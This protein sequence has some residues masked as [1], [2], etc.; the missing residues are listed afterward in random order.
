[1]IVCDILAISTVIFVT[2]CVVRL[3]PNLNLVTPGPGTQDEF[4][5]ATV[6]ATP[7]QRHINVLISQ[8]SI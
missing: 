5:D 8:N 4:G 2:L 7:R 6:A 3:A 1:M